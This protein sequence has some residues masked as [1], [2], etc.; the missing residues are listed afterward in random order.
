M[1]QFTITNGTRQV[2][3]TNQ[4]VGH[5]AATLYVNSGETITRQNWTGKT[6]KGARNWA[7]KVLGVSAEVHPLL[8]IAAAPKRQP[9]I[10]DRVYTEGD[11]ANS[12]KDGTIVAIDAHQVQIVWDPEPACPFDHVHDADCEP[13]VHQPTWVYQSMLD[14]TRWGWIDDRNRRRHEAIEAMRARLNATT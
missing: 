9:L 2:I 10:G 1:R 11:M 12:P 13:A 3:V 5:Y 8:S 6:E 4:S 7:A 14:N